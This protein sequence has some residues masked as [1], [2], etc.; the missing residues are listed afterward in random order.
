MGIFWSKGISQYSRSWGL[1]GSEFIPDKVWENSFMSGQI[2]T[3]HS[4]YSVSQDDETVTLIQMIHL[5]IG[6]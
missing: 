3:A 4:G 1:S 5:H 6:E 2:L